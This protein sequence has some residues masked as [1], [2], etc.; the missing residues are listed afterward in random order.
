MGTLDRAEEVFR[1]EFMSQPE[2]LADR[3]LF[4]IDGKKNQV[5]AVISLWIGTLVDTPRTRLHWIATKEEYQ[6][7]GLIKAAFTYVMDLYHKLGCEGYAYLT[8]QTGS[9]K[10][11]NIYKKFGFVPYWGEL[12]GEGSDFDMESHQKSWQIINGKI[13]EYKAGK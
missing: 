12:H 3:C 5:A 6:G 13:A 7:L 9:Y 1:K 4:V 10:A 2:L 11:I 8:T